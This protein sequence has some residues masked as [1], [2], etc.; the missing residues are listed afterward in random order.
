MDQEVRIDKLLWC[1]RLFKTRSLATDACNAGKVT[2][3]GV[4]VKP[5]KHAAIDDVISVRQNPIVKTVKVINLPSS[6]IGA[7]LVADNYEDMTPPEEYEKLEMM[8]QQKT[9]WRDNAGRPTKKERREID[10]FKEDIDE[11]EWGED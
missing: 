10:R 9:I 8:R 3:N 5:S 2:V 11:D 4:V 1:L 6:R 7:K